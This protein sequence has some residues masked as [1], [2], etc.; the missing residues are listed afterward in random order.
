MSSL[1]VEDVVKEVARMLRGFV[2]CEM[3]SVVDRLA[4]ATSKEAVQEALYE[5]LRAARA[6][7]GS[8]LCEKTEP[9]VA[10]EEAVDYVLRKLDENLLEGLEIVRKIVIRALAMPL[11]KEEKAG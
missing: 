10:S 1:T 7:Q 9:Y 8:E 2:V 4:N 11:K 5:A 3:Y 6:A